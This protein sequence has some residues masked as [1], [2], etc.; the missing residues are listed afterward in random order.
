VAVRLVLIGEDP[1]ARGGLHAQLERAPEVELRGSTSIDHLA[2]ALHDHQPEAFIWDLGVDPRGALSR[3]ASLAQTGVPFVALLADEALAGEAVG[4]GAAGVLEREAPPD[5]IAA[6]AVAVAAGL[7]VAPA[8]MAAA[9]GLPR[10][11]GGAPPAEAL[12][13]REVEVMQLLSEGLSNKQIA[14]RL[15]ISEHTA[16]FHVNAILGKLGVQSRTEAVVR[17]ARL[18]LVML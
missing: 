2:L 11:S 14:A 17:A 15:E 10:P 13:E 9:A 4:A 1:L 3:A 12:T 16:K 6:A 5:Q 18:G 8:G 7:V